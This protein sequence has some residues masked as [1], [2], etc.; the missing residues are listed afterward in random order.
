VC[1]HGNRG[2]CRPVKQHESLIFNSFGQEW[3]SV[4]RSN[5]LYQ[6][7]HTEH[8]V[9]GNIVDLRLSTGFVE[10]EKTEEYNQTCVLNELLLMLK[11]E[12]LWCCGGSAAS[13]Y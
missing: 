10:S 4:A 5:K 12:Q 13:E 8:L 7:E 3:S 6:P 9:A 2:T 1:V 11:A